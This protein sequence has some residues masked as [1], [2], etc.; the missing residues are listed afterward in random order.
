VEEI[1]GV[2]ERCPPYSALSALG[3]YD[4]GPAGGLVVTEKG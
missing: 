4:L 1:L 2:E 3:P